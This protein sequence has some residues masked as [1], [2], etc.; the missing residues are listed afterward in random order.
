MIITIDLQRFILSNLFF[1]DMK[2]NIIMDGN[3][4]KLIYSN[5]CFTMNGLYVLFPIE[6]GTERGINRNQIKFNPYSPFN[7]TTIQDFSKLEMKILEYYKQ[8][9][10]CNRKLSILLSRQMHSGC[11]KTHKENYDVLTED[12]KNIQYVVKFSGVWETREEVGLTYKLY[13]VDENYL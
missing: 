2:R 3:F 9:K 11:M 10:Q 5:E 1:L 12:K 6:I 8:S 7:Q 13:E 4:T